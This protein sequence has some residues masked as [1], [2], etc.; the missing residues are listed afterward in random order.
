MTDCKTKYSARGTQEFSLGCS[1]GNFMKVRQG[2]QF[3]INRPGFKAGAI[4]NHTSSIPPPLQPNNRTGDGNRKLI[5]NHFVAPAIKGRQV[6]SFETLQAQ[7]ISEGG[8][9]VQFG[10]DD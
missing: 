9:K 10:Q 5:R 4:F 1:R 2:T 7:D 3:N 6:L 8:I